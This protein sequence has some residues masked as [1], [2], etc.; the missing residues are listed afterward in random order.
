MTKVIEKSNVKV[1]YTGSLP[2]TNEI[3]DTSNE[4]IAKE[5]GIHNPE[6]EYA[7]LDVQVGEHQVIPGFEQALIGMEVGDKKSITIPPEEA[8]GEI[9]PQKVVPVPDSQFE[10]SEIPLEPGTMIQT[11][12]GIACITEYNESEKMVTLDF[13]APLAGKTLK[14]ELELVEI[15]E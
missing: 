4:A 6:R 13:N 5:N 11:S 3:F 2:D 12:A 10:G 9:D 1:H 14:F 15:V 7:P 8:Y